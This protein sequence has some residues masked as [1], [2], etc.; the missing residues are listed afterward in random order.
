[1]PLKRRFERLGFCHLR[2]DN[3]PSC[4]Q[5]CFF[6][7]NPL[8]NSCDLFRAVGSRTYL[9]FQAKPLERYIRGVSLGIQ[10]GSL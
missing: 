1:M 9:E 4:L 5:I 10:A 2:R 7:T 8:V 3:Q 6:D